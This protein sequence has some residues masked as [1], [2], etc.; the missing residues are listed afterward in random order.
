MA[1]LN[2]DDTYGNGLRTVIQT[3]LCEAGPLDESVIL[4]RRF[5]VEN[6]RGNS[7]QWPQIIEQLQS[8]VPDVI[9]FIGFVESGISCSGMRR[10][11]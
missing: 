7:D 10:F 4:S 6:D 11:I 9:V 3:S 5:L 2:L 1:I 8:F